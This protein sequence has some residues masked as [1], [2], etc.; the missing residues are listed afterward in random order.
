MG[1]PLVT[2]PPPPPFGGKGE[3]VATNDLCVR[4]VNWCATVLLNGEE[5]RAP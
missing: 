1:F 5:Q 3:I 4:V 2:P